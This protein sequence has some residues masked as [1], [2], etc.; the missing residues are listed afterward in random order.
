MSL[1]QVPEQCTAVLLS[2]SI[3]K[4]GSVN[5]DLILVSHM[6]EVVSELQYTGLCEGADSENVGGPQSPP[7]F[8]EE[9]PP[10]AIKSNVSDKGTEAM[11]TSPNRT[12]NPDSPQ[13]DSPQEDS[14]QKDSR[15][16]MPRKR[17]LQEDSPQDE[18][19]KRTLRKTM[20]RKRTLRKTMPRKRTPKTP[21]KRTPCKR[22]PAKG[23]RKRTL[24]KTIPCKRILQEDSSR[25]VPPLQN[26][27]CLLEKLNH[28]LS[29]KLL[30][31][32][33]FA[34]PNPF[35]EMENQMG[36]TFPMTNYQNG[37]EEDRFFLRLLV[38][39]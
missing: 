32:F 38:P 35:L 2:D 10:T 36:M 1:N 6:G 9:A 4:N 29:L 16:T 30:S 39:K 21:C 37:S 18:P 7:D 27:P 5:S 17:T 25:E 24:R 31:M 14:L 11:R 20:P 28:R 13:E 34:Y 12:E 26:D 23:L 8:V 19:R 22:L 3:N 15:K 33:V